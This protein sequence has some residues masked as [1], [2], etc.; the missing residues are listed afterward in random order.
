MKY[1]S[2]IVM[3]L[4]LGPAM[5]L[6][7]C[8]G[9]GVPSIDPTPIP[10]CTATLNPPTITTQPVAQTVVAGGS[11]TYSVA[12]S[13]C[14]I[15]YQWLSA[16]SL[17]AVYSAIRGATSASYTVSNAGAAQNGLYYRV[18][19][20]NTFGS[21]PSNPALLTVTGL[22]GPG[23]SAADSC[24]PWLLG[25]GTE[26]RTAFSTT[27]PPSTGETVQTVTAGVTFEGQPRTEVRVLGPL[28]SAT[29]DTRLYGTP[30]AA[31]GNVTQYGTLS[32]VSISSAGVTNSNSVKSVLT[33]PSV[34][35][36]FALAPGATAP[37]RT[38]TV[39]DTTIASI[40]GVDQPPATTTRTETSPATTFVGYETVTVPAGTFS[41]CKY[42]TAGST[43]ARWVLKG[44][45]STVKDSSGG[46]ATTIKVNG[47]VITSN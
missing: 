40:N 11:A 2:L 41:T 25:S 15:A 37:A 46:Q 17:V 9:G 42:T 43:A 34:D 33:Q 47:S 35:T 5:L 27:V 8:G 39:A 26:V 4:L 29:L 18:L 45:G 21:V 20:T 19:V 30:D 24:G 16:P 23:P 3:L 28:L 1:R 13:N 10:G 32:V 44:Y 12:A 36:Q 7:G 14:P 38:L 22:S 31:T 6:T